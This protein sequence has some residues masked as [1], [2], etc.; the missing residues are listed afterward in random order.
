MRAF[1]SGLIAFFILMYAGV[2][3]DYFSKTMQ[4]Y[5][6]MKRD[7]NNGYKDWD[8]LRPA[9]LGD[10]TV[11][12]RDTPLGDVKPNAADT[13]KKQRVSHGVR[14]H[15]GYA[16]VRNGI[17]YYSEHANAITRTGIRDIYVV[18]DPNDFGKAI[19]A[20][21]HTDGGYI[22]VDAEIT[23]VPWEQ[24]H[25]KDELDLVNG[26]FDVAKYNTM[27]MTMLNLYRRKGCSALGISNKDANGV[28]RPFSGGLQPLRYYSDLLQPAKYHVDYLASVPI[29]SNHWQ[30]YDVSGHEELYSISDRVIKWHNLDRVVYENINT[31][32]AFRL[33]RTTYKELAIKNIAA[34]HRSTS[35]HRETMQRSNIK[36]V[37][38][39]AAGVTYK[40]V[41]KGKESVMASFVSLTLFK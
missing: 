16:S 19:V 38:P 6:E 29:Y 31:F 17:I 15:E 10:D 22:P 3:Y 27:L 24:T 26:Q 1:I 39:Y 12:M 21:R 13:Q 41:Y 28:A 37:A 11:G 34:W 7:L 35:G 2:K 36:Y 9:V 33:N 30:P 25:G 23:V 20:K 8:S 40:V 14:K 5:F 4:Y 32:N 18:S